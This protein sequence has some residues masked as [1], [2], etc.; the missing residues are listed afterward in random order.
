MEFP[1][2]LER[3]LRQGIRQARM[4]N[5]SCCFVAPAMYLICLCSSVL[6][7]QWGRFLAG[8]GLLRWDDPLVKGLE[9]GAGAVL[10]LALVLPPRLGH[11]RDSRGALAVLKMRNLAS[12]ALVAGIAVCGLVLGVRIG[13]SAASLSLIICA[14]A[15]VAGLAVFPRERRWREVMTIAGRIGPKVMDYKG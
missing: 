6:G 2:E 4:V 5:F 7:G 15:M 12:S 14:V 8:F 3:D 11:L 13:P 10:I 9:M 1:P